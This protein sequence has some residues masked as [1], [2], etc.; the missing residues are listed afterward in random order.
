MMENLEKKFKSL[1]ELK[2]INKGV[3][4]LLQYVQSQSFRAVG[5]SVPARNKGSKSKSNSAKKE[6]LSDLA[7][8]SEAVQ[9][10]PEKQSPLKFEDI[11]ETLKAKSFLEPG[12]SLKS[13]D[14]STLIKAKKS[15]Q[16]ALKSATD[17]CMHSVRAC[18]ESALQMKKNT[19]SLDEKYKAL[20]PEVISKLSFSENLSAY[21]LFDLHDMDAFSQSD[22]FDKIKLQFKLEKLLEYVGVPFRSIKSMDQENNDQRG[23]IY[24]T[25]AKETI[26]GF[27]ILCEWFQ[28][29]Y[30]GD[31]KDKLKVLKDVGPEEICLQLNSF[32]KSL[33]IERENEKYDPVSTAD[34]EIAWGHLVMARKHKRES[35]PVY[36][37]S[38]GAIKD[39]IKLCGLD[40]TLVID[41]H[42]GGGGLTIGDYGRKL[43][44]EELSNI[45][46]NIIAE[47]REKISHVILSSCA[48]GTLVE[49]WANDAHF[50]RRLKFAD[51]KNRC[52]LHVA[53]GT[54]IEEM[55]ETVNA[56]PP[57]AAQLASI[58][59]ENYKHS[60]MGVAF[61]F[62]PSMLIPQFKSGNRAYVSQNEGARDPWPKSLSKE[63]TWKHD[64]RLGMQGNRLMQQVAFKS[65][66]L[67]QS[68]TNRKALF[69]KDDHVCV[70]K[71]KKQI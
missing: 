13:L 10:Q 31:D 35:E 55:F 45:F 51:F 41:G 37:I 56:K 50:K 14:R 29:C 15:I 38:V 60:Q 69:V 46:I 11:I 53:K 66:T 44:R 17:E 18:L 52:K 65:V 5:S 57:V 16:Q 54:N 22:H 27:S 20:L 67:Y 28:K 40:S 49:K 47:C 39:A 36:V 62:S 25:T 1:L 9:S 63:I 21:L 68:Q 34:L 26:D 71:K 70:W 7:E 64:N 4:T 23:R 6:S 33:S 59:F 2:S 42:G 48:T 32:R 58:I 8:S 30:K 24:F 12:V 19:I 3:C 61:T 43:K